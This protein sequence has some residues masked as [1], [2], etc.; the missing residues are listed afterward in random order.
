MDIKLNNIDLIIIVVYLLVILSLGCWY[1][2][3]AY[4]DKKKVQTDSKGYFLAGGNLKWPVI[5]LSLFATNISTIHMV[6]LAQAGYEDGL[7]NGNYELMS[8]F[9]IIILAIFFV[10]FYIRSRVA[11][12][13]DFLEQRFDRASRDWVAGISIASAILVHI[14]FSLVTGAVVLEGMFGFDK[15][16]SILLIVLLTGAYTIVG[17]L[18]AVVFTESLQAIILILGAI[19]VT[20]AAYLKLGSWDVLVNNIDK[21]ALNLLRS[22][23]ESH[24][25]WYAVFLG[26]PVIGIWYWCT[27]QTIVQRVLGAKDEEHARVGAIFSGFLKLLPMFIFVLPGLMVVALINT[28]KIDDTLL[29]SKD[30]LSFLIRNLLPP[31]L[32]GLMAAALLAAVMSSVSGALNSISTLF[33]YDLYK[34]F[35]PKTPDKKLVRIGRITAFVAMIVSVLWSFAIEG[36]EGIFNEMVGIVVL[37]SPPLTM[38]FL[39]GIFWKKASSF[40][41]KWTLWL[42]SLAGV[43][44]YVYHRTYEIFGFPEWKPKTLMEGVY[45]SIICT[46]IM[47]V[48]SYWKPQEQTEKSKA[49]TWAYFWEPLEPK[50]WKG[51]GNYK[52]LS[53]LLLLAMALIYIIF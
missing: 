23:E 21:S 4:I 17:G 52:F 6:G 27:D 35:K 29:E 1:Y 34:R 40:A 16:A 33:T 50:G 15:T 30:T 8:G 45:L 2:I 42:G 28:G 19:A 38:V 13:P 49:L 32:T 44:V 47:V 46:I 26:Y 31:G 53:V 24:F 10:P 43:L 51:I 22:G 14:G 18:R 20:V 3:K 7:L 25:P 48:F 37:I 36:K 11:T 39:F 41:S 9:V 5:G 12:L